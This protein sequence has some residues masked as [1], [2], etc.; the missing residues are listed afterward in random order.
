MLESREM[1]GAEPMYAKIL[2]SA[3]TLLVERCELIT[4]CLAVLALLAVGVVWA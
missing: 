4:N 1:T 2:E 3:K